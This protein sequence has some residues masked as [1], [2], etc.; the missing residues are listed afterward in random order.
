M[1]NIA[2]K[3]IIFI[4]IIATYLIS[5]TF[6]IAGYYLN[7]SI[8]ANMKI[9]VAPKDKVEIV[10]PLESASD[11]AGLVSE[12]MIGS[13]KRE[14]NFKEGSVKMITKNEDDSPVINLV[15]EATSQQQLNLALDR[16]SDYRMPEVFADYFKMDVF[17]N[18]VV[19]RTFFRPLIILGSSL[20]FL[21]SLILIA[22]ILPAND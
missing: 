8:R 18:P 1:K 5:L 17:E 10:R 7:P 12:D 14:D 4:S 19:S 2:T 22:I 20:I 13:M 9:I 21:F 11:V 15:I 3:K 16:V 6:L